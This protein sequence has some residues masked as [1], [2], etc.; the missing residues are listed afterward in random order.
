M[1]VILSIFLIFCILAFL[2]SIA[3]QVILILR[4]PKS[5]DAAAKYWKA[6][7]KQNRGH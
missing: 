5:P 7:A 4:A 3:T 1:N 2:A 6:V